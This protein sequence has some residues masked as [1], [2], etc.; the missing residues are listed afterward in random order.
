MCVSVCVFVCACARACVCVQVVSAG[1]QAAPRSSACYAANYDELRDAVE[2]GAA[3]HDTL[4][5]D[6]CV[7]C[8][9]R[10]DAI[11]R[12]YVRTYD[13]HTHEGLIRCQLR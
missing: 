13:T 4:P 2:V 7:V 10:L 6:P 3:A 1:K 12:T 9:A 8:V 11:V 5:Y